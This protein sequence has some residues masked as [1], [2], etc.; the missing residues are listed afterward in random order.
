MPGVVKT[1]RTRTTTLTLDLDAFRFLQEFAPS[2]K[3]YV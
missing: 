1:D 3:G 2:H